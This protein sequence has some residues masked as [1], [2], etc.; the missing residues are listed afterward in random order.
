MNSSE[1]VLSSRRLT[2]KVIDENYADEVLNYFKRNEKFLKKWEPKRSEELYTLK[3]QKNQLR[4]DL[5]NISKGNLLKL[6]IFPKGDNKIIG[7]LIFSNIVRGCFQS[8]YLGY[9]LDEGK[10]N[11]GY[12]TEALEELIRFLFEELKLHRIEANIIPENKASLRVV[13]KLGFYNE[14][15]ARKYLKIND[16]WEDYIHMVLLNEGV[17]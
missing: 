4:D 6:W 16:K 14:G 15:L 10:V 1:I 2:L 11:S 13:E 17:E 8:C 5:S 12:M 9:R 7:S 3:Y